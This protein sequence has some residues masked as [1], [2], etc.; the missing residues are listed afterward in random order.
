M[1]GSGHPNFT[2]PFEYDK[3]LQGKSFSK[4]IGAR[5]PPNL[6]ALLMMRTTI[7][8]DDG[9]TLPGASVPFE[10]RA[11]ATWTKRRG[12]RGAREAAVG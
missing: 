11:E 3:S 10:Q 7:N 6:R 1:E 8:S 5:T 2:N 4:R 12:G 9:K